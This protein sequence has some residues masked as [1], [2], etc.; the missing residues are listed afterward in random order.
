MANSYTFSP[1]G[2][3]VSSPSGEVTL[4]AGQNINIL[5]QGNLITISAVIPPLA[6]NVIAN[7]N[8]LPWQPPSFADAD[9]PNNSI[10]FSTDAGVL[11]YK[12]DA[13]VVNNLY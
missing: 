12:D 8:G 7:G 4:N 2:V 11:V 10:Y 5:P 1:Y 6:S 3:T 13:A 9:A